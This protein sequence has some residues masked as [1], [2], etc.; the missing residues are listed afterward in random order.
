MLAPARRGNCLHQWAFSAL[1]FHSLAGWWGKVERVGRCSSA[2]ARS[3]LRSPCQSGSSHALMRRLADSRSGKESCV[4]P[5]SRE[6]R[7]RAEDACRSA[8]R[9]RAGDRRVDGDLPTRAAGR[10]PVLGP[11]AVYRAAAATREALGER[12]R[13]VL[14]AACRRTPPRVPARAERHAISGSPR[15]CRWTETLSRRYNSPPPQ[16]NWQ[17]H[18]NAVASVATVLAMTPTEAAATATPVR[19]R[20]VI[21]GSC[22]MTRMG[23]HPADGG[24]SYFRN[25]K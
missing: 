10:E 21:E 16:H 25:R 3:A 2:S 19:V 13:G 4:M 12:H 6:P 8:Y 14:D 20:L 11:A 22:E 9:R 1:L 15:V 23:C 5:I 17:A 18:E 24:G 7:C